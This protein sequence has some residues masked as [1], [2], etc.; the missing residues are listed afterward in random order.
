MKLMQ[1]AFLLFAAVAAGGVLLS[2]LVGLRL[3]F[4]AW[5]GSAHGLAGLGALAFLFAT[6]LL[7]GAETT[8]RAWW[9]L[10][11][12][13]SGFFGGLLLFRVIFK[14]RATLPLAL[15]HGSLGALGLYLLYG[16]AFVG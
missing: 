11:V 12:F 6:N 7:G 4:P 10:G 14:Q 13:T 8:P 15:M 5:L 9:A 3:R 16:A 2:L 1:V